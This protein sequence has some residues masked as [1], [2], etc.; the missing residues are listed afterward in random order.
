MTL[1]K[2]SPFETVPHRREKGW[3]FAPCFSCYMKVSCTNF[4][5]LARVTHGA[6]SIQLFLFP[7][8]GLATSRYIVKNQKFLLVLESVALCCKTDVYLV[9][10]IWTHAFF[11]ANEQIVILSL[12]RSFVCKHRTVTWQ[13][14]DL[15]NCL[16]DLKMY[17][18]RSDE[19]IF[20][21]TRSRIER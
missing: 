20:L 4:V 15:S 19:A 13:I 1:S 21:G 11:N 7:C 18:S 6:T 9:C 17:I 8:V 3:Q 2:L 10:S 14:L 12:S 5:S 16:E